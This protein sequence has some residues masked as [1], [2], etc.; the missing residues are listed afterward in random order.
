MSKDCN[1]GDDYLRD[2]LELDLSSQLP[3]FSAT[4]T[5]KF[6][7]LVP[8]QP[9]DQLKGPVDTIITSAAKSIGLSVVCK[10]ES[11]VVALGRP[12]F[13]VAVNSLLTGHIELKPPGTGANP[14]AYVGHNKDQ[15]QR[16]QSLPNLIY[17]DGNEWSLFRTGVRVG[18]IVRLN[19]NVV[20]DGPSAIG[21][22]DAHAIA[23]ILRDFFSWRPIVPTDPEQLAALLAPLCRYLRLS[24][25]SLLAITTSAVSQL[26]IDWQ[27]YLFP[28]ADD[29]QFSDAYAQTIVY[30][31][32][33]AHFEGLQSVSTSIAPTTLA[34]EHSLLGAVLR[35]LSDASARAELETPIALLERVISA[36]DVAAISTAG[37]LWIYFY[38]YFL[39]AYDPALR[40]DRGVYYTPAQVVH[41]QVTLVSEVLVKHFGKSLSFADDGVVTLDPAAGTGT[42]SLGIIEHSMKLI[43][44]RFGPG[45]VPSYATALASNLHAFE[46]L[47][48]PYA[49]AHLRTS[50][51][52]KAYGAALPTAGAQVYLTDTLDS[53]DAIIPGLPLLY[54]PLTAELTRALSVKRNTRVL[55]CIG[56]PPYDREQREDDG[57]EV[58]RK[59]GWV[60]FG[61]L[62]AD[63]RP[64]LADFTEPAQASGAAIHLKNLYNDYVY[65]WRWALWKVFEQHEGPGVVSFITA[66][67]YLKGPGFV[68]MRE[69]MRRTFDELW[70]IDL[71]GDN[72]GARPSQNVFNIQIPV[73]I[74]VGVRYGTPKPNSPA[75]VHRVSIRGSRQDKY[76]ALQGL[77]A[78]AGLNWE[79][80][81]SGWQDEFNPSRF[82]SYLGMPALK[83]ILPW[84]TS[85]VQYKRNWPI[86]EDQAIL[87]NRWST[88]MSASATSRAALFKETAAR[89]VT[90]TYRPISGFPVTRSVALEPS[91]APCPTCRR[92]GFR[93]FDRRWIIA[94]GRMAD[95]MRPALWA[96]DG[97]S[98]TYMCTFF[99][100]TIGTGPAATLSAEIPDLH[101]FRGSFG[102]ADVVPLW[103]DPAGT[104]PNVNSRLK[105]A[106]EVALGSP[107]SEDS[108]F[109]Y[110]YALLSTP[111]YTSQYWDELEYYGPRIPLTTDSDLFADVVA[112]GRH[113]I[114]L[115]SYSM[116]MVD[117]SQGRLSSVAQGTARS[118]NAISGNANGYPNSLEYD[119]AT[120]TLTIGTGTF[121]P[122]DSDVWNYSCSG[123][124]VVRSWVESRLK[125]GSGKRTSPLDD[126]R[127]STWSAAF[128]SELLELLWILE[129]TL[130]LA[131]KQVILL[132]K[133]VASNQLTTWDEPLETEVSSPFE[134][135]DALTLGV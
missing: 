69:K 118:L 105:A 41:A 24:A 91:A 31:L 101:Y 130:S 126:I 19:G 84:R 132:Q 36:I 45:A 47:V 3:L 117:A 66:A 110:C 109:C 93:S 96:S 103:R 116:R 89:R 99:E 97:P 62:G 51:R 16:F 122:I 4:I 77:S 26:K 94:D 70:I 49:V 63:E 75:Q 58:D 80:C 25:Q 42:Y 48:G 44:N 14:R 83:D 86:G 50:E 106:L 28:N 133:V 100:S 56:N 81:L 128:T 119:A 131:Q 53:P 40:R 87:V 11:A 85:G 9:E 113:L 32:L 10:T 123:L 124:Q 74:A 114:W 15:W 67:S 72:R 52:F 8:G 43:A 46:L 79:P 88:L 73:C 30:A 34:A 121:G 115:H 55:V 95:R 13:G 68:G 71:G 23:D 37:D 7:T 59:G 29:D 92:Y 108:L 78:F 65:F 6:S 120:K 22:A 127:P 54:R 18:N 20:T 64:I 57:T 39:A 102:G 38:E 61:T 33:L 35:I 90:K 112:M 76:E 104:R 107:I 12:D 2:P 111:A 129:H 5:S 17:T 98:Q 27:N 125:D 1:R 135:D 82:V 21:P 60:R 134:E